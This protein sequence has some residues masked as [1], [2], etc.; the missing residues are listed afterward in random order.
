[1]DCVELLSL[2]PP[3]QHEVGALPGTYL[4]EATNSCGNH[5][6]ATRNTSTH[7]Q[8]ASLSLH[9]RWRSALCGDCP[10]RCIAAR[11]AYPPVHAVAMV[12]LGNLRS[13]AVTKVVL[14]IASI[15]AVALFVSELWR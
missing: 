5:I 8:H 2:L 13:S 7:D 14:S 9:E 6:H 1:M 11:T 12:P 3:S 10:A 15:T 4:R